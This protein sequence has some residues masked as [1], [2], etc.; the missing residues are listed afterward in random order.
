MLKNTK[1]ISFITIFAISLLIIIF[2]KE[3]TIF[4]NHSMLWNEYYAKYWALTNHPLETKYNV[5]IVLFLA[6]YI[7]Y[8]NKNYKSDISRIIMYIIWLQILIALSYYFIERPFMRQSPNLALSNLIS[9]NEIMPDINFK[10]HSNSSLPSGHTL[11]MLYWT[12]ILWPMG[13]Q[14]ICRFLLILMTISFGFGRIF[15]GLH[16][17]SDILSG[18]L[19]AYIWLKL[20][21]YIATYCINFI[22]L[23]KKITINYK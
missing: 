15:A 23:K 14:K 2:D 13:K 9:L 19:L 6:I 20:F 7:V 8:H 5:I 12:M 18:A 16:W 11:N 4:L 21:D 17:A 1:F 10:T 22:N 3:I